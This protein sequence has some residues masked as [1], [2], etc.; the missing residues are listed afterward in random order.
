MG[1]VLFSKCRIFAHNLKLLSKKRIEDIQWESLSLIKNGIE[2]GNLLTNQSRK[3]LKILNSEETLDLLINNP[4]SFYRYGDGEMNIIM[5]GEAGTQKADSDL[6]KRLLEALTTERDDI[7]IGIGYRYFNFNLWDNNIYSN[8]FYM[9]HADVYRSFLCEYCST[10]RTYIDTGFNQ[11]YFFMPPNKMEQW[12]NKAKLLFKGKKI[13]LFM[14][15]EA[16]EKLKY[17]VFE[18]ADEIHYVFC[19]SRDAYKDY[20]YIMEK[21]RKRDFE[22][23]LCFALGAAAKVMIYELS[24]DGYTG[25][26]IGHLPKDYDSY[27]RKIEVSS[28]NK[29]RFY[30]DDYKLSDRVN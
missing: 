25:Y 23:V 10:G 14:G 15:K 5:G 2:Y 22:E 27:M 19:S 20:E 12:F 8:R 18:E 28:E 6:A 21:A 11:Q 26:D 9:E 16:Y 30:R 3:Q 24:R 1:K 29:E 7:Y 13:C 4:K 17:Y